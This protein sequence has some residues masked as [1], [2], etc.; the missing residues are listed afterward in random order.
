MLHVGPCARRNI[1]LGYTA[2]VHQ[3]RLRPYSCCAAP[4]PQPENKHEEKLNPQPRGGFKLPQLKAPS[5]CCRSI[6]QQLATEARGQA[7]LPSCRLASHSLGNSGLVY[8]YCHMSGK[9]ETPSF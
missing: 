6:L 7:Q 8:M 2:S 1:C 3:Y 9:K 4:L 5:T